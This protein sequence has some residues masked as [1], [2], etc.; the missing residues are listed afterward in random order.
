MI[1]TV[2]QAKQ[3]IVVVIS[4]RNNTNSKTYPKP[5]FTIPPSPIIHTYTHTLYLGFPVPFLGF[6]VFKIEP[7][8]IFLQKNFSVVF[9][10][11]TFTTMLESCSTDSSSNCYCEQNNNLAWKMWRSCI[12]VLNELFNGIMLL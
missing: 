1:L 5:S 9:T 2:P 10:W 11:D 12:H 4:K 3:I 7:V 6:R 8:F